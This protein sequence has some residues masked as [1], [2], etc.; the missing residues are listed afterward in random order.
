MS[1]RP[2]S[3]PAKKVQIDLIADVETVTPGQPFWLALRQRITP[4]WHTYWKNP[5]DSGEPTQIKWQMPKG[6]EA[7]AIYWPIP[8]VIPVGTLINYGYSDDVLLLTKI[9]PPAELADGPIN[10]SAKAGWLVCEKICIPEFGEVSLELEGLAKDGKPTPSAEAPIISE[11]ARALPRKSPWPVTVEVAKNKVRLTVDSA[12]FAPGRVKSLRFLPE[13]WGQIDIGAKQAVHWSDGSPSLVLQ[14]GELKDEKLER[15]E[16]LLVVEETLDRQDVRHGFEISAQARA[17]SDL[18]L[19]PQSSSQFQI[20]LW[21]A[22]LFAFLGGAILNLMPCVF[23]VLSLKA[24]TLARHGEGEME[25]R[26]RHGVAYLAG[27]LASFIVFA[28]I[29][30]A[31]RHAGS[32][33]GWGF[34]FQSPLFVLA[35]ATLFFVLGLNLSGV[36]QFGS[37]FVG[38]GNSL[39]EKSGPTG[40]FFT[41]ALAS[42]AATPCT[43][44]FMGAAM[45]FALAQSDLVTLLV[46]LALGLGFAVPMTALSF[47]TPLARLLPKP[48]PWMETLKQVLAFPLYASAA[49]LVWVLS[50]QVGSAGVLAA[51]VVLVG[52]GFVAW[53]LGTP[54]RATM[55]ARFASVA[56]LLVAGVVGYQ[57]LEQGRSSQ[58]DSRHALA[59]NS[60]AMPFSKATLEKYLGGGRSVFV[61]FTAAWCITCKVNEMVALNSER[62]RET[63]RDHEIVY[64]KGDWTNQDSEISS[65]LKAYGRAGVPL[66]LFYRAGE[67]DPEVLPQILTESLVVGRLTADTKSASAE[68]NKP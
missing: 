53:L 35:M 54:S 50:I 18:E 36:F 32:I 22:L 37:G 5:G 31:L 2:E 17:A 14:R 52:V 66:Y 60:V 19:A 11:A 45:G 26:R 27:V 9:T 10:I 46:F 12:Q 38:L 43:A 33:M 25:E 23:P 4:N 3:G 28:L 7:S 55:A 57:L 8:D 68:T 44:P 65:V 30:I 49:W 58:S 24:L 16:G 56:I 64:L 47:S 67:K 20:G 21:Q 59:A 61:N 51:A 40:S 6:F 62:F 39:A 42:I 13:A 41:G 15:L 29:L 48:G 1:T 63:L 34:Q